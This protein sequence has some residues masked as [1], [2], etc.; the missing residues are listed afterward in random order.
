MKLSLYF[1]KGNV[2]IFA[3]LVDTK[4]IVI[5][6]KNTSRCLD[7]SVFLAF[8]SISSNFSQKLLLMWV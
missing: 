4:W 6:P 3:L 8:I 7:F 2:D 1:A 5:T